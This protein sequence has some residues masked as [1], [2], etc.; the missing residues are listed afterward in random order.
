MDFQNVWKALK[1]ARN[2]LRNYR[3]L[4]RPDQRTIRKQVLLFFVKAFLLCWQNRK[5]HSLYS[6]TMQ[7]LRMLPEAL[8]LIQLPCGLAEL[9]WREYPNTTILWSCRIC[10]GI[11]S[12]MDLNLSKWVKLIANCWVAWLFVLR[13]IAWEPCLL[14]LSICFHRRNVKT[15]DT[16]VKLCNF[17]CL[18]ATS[19]FG[20]IHGNSHNCSFRR[21]KFL[22]RCKL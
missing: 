14:Q 8:N 18:Q 6:H 9:L 15:R 10:A 7:L 21:G 3:N 5:F 19:P 17:Q 4:V 11:I 2:S 22:Q 13:L 1:I 20:N 16:K 12:A